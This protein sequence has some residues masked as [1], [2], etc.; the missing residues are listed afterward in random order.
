MLLIQTDLGIDTVP[1]SMI[2]ANVGI[3]DTHLVSLI[4]ADVVIDKNPV[5]LV[6]TDLG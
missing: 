3:E 2:Q 4:Q 5:S 1:E 6:H